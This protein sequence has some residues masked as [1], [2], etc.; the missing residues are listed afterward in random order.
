MKRQRDIEIAHPRRGLQVEHRLD[1]GSVNEQ[2]AAPFQVILRSIEEQIALADADASQHLRLGHGAAHSQVGVAGNLGQ[3][4]LH[5]QLRRRNNAHIELYGIEQ[6]FRL[7]HGRR[8]IA[9]RQI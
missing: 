2:N 4:S 7:G 8:L 3:R 9:A 1:A 5:L 6:R